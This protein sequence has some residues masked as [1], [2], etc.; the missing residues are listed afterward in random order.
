MSEQQQNW[1]G[2]NV[3]GRYSLGKQLGGTEHSAVF[4]TEIV[5][6]RSQ[7][8]A[9]KLLPAAGVDVERQLAR[10]K[11]LS[12]VSHAN[13][14]KIFD[15]GKCELDGDAYLFLVMEYADEDLA[16]ILP[17]RALNADET[18]GMIEPVVET[19]AFLHG[20]GLVHARL[21]PGNILATGDQIKLS[22]DS[23]VPEGEA[24]G[25]TASATGFTPPEW[26]SSLA[27][28]AGDV[29]SLGATVI[30]ALTQKAPAIGENGEVS[31]PAGVTEPFA[32]IARDALKKEASQRIT[33][34]GIR[35]KLNA[36]SAPVPAPAVVEVPKAPA[37]MVAKIDPVAVPLSKM[38]PPAVQERRP[39]APVRAVKAKGPGRNSYWMPMAGLAVVAI[40]LLSVAKLF[41][42]GSDASPVDAATKSSTG[43]KSTRP[44]DASSKTS[45]TMP[46]KNPPAQTTLTETSQPS[47]SLPAPAVTVPKKVASAPG[48]RGEVLD[49]VVPEVSEKARATIQ[50]KVRIS[51]KVQVN[52]SG[53]VD[54]AELDSPASSKYFSE[55]AIKATK[56]W[57]FSAPEVDGHSV[58]SEW[59][60]H[61]EF[62]SSATTV[63]A[64]QVSP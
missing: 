42:H 15:Y 54:S 43:E 53:T 55:Q 63:Q 52:P 25:A 32:S 31:L 61:F 59:L 14:L 29:W 41:R 8:V 45:M 38:A 56:K 26:N 20:R 60:L 11:S 4:A 1:S 62:T 27:T 19:L 7:Q 51:V 37:K 50:G 23:I 34:A 2:R 39:P 24:I 58:A 49:Q 64:T 3:A 40:L 46:K 10:W 18:R 30:A 12:S 28:V 44:T 48:T 21:H 47:K 6:A 9:I 16:D 17:H 13:L 57:Q 36:A 5:H 33:L 35:A 22:S